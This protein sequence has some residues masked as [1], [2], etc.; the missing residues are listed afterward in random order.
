M[1]L[2]KHISFVHITHYSISKIENNNHRQ[3]ILTLLIPLWKLQS[4]FYDISGPVH[5]QSNMKYMWG[6]LPRHIIIVYWKY[7]Q[8]VMLM[9]NINIIQLTARNH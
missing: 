8:P 2:F 1:T 9:V 4:V 6:K 5:F 7:I 3:K